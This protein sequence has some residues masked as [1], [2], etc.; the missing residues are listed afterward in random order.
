MQYNKGNSSYSTKEHLL[1]YN[2][3]N[4]NVDIVCISEANL[5]ETYIKDNN[6]INGYSCETK[7]M[8]DTVDISR[9]IILVNDR[10]PYT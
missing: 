3:T 10:I 1:N 2:I 4:H 8:S 7:P 9:N 5:T 6:T